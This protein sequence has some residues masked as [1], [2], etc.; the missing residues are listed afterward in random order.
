MTA[1]R[2]ATTQVAEARATATVGGGSSDGGSGSAD[3]AEEASADGAGSE[4]SARAQGKRRGDVVARERLQ[5]TEEV[6][7][8]GS[9]TSNAL[10]GAAIHAELIVMC[11]AG[12]PDEVRRTVVLHAVHATEIEEHSGPDDGAGV[13]GCDEVSRAAAWAV[14]ERAL[15]D[16]RALMHARLRVRR[17]QWGSTSAATPA[18]CDTAEAGHATRRGRAEQ[19]SR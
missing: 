15:R 11:A 2:A 10:R 5:R 6:A 4:L 14:A 19:A 7:D 9:A 13:F 16:A 3:G 18:V 12:L 1:A 8:T 17:R